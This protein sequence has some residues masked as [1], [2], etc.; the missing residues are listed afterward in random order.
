MYDI[1]RCITTYTFFISS[2]CMHLKILKCIY[3]KLQRFVLY[4]KKNIYI[5]NLVKSILLS[6]NYQ[7]KLSSYLIYQFYNLNNIL[8]Q[9]GKNN[10]I[11]VPHLLTIVIY[12]F[13]IYRRIVN[14]YLKNDNLISDELV[15]DL[16]LFLMLFI[17]LIYLS[18]SDFLITSNL[19]ISI[20]Y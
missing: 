9:L 3:L 18:N 8:N 5:C 4:L 13:Y 1:T 17:L 11:T 2:A 15:Y 6:S 20:V 12:Y 19:F 7:F 14:R 10:A 16:K